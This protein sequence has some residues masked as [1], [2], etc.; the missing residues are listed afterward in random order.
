MT[1]R[2]ERLVIEAIEAAGHDLTSLL[3][4]DELKTG[5]PAGDAVHHAVCALADARAVFWIDELRSRAS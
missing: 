1:P 5:T 2:D 3:G 4:H